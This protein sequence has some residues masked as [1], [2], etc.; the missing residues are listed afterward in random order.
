MLSFNALL[1]HVSSPI[2]EPF[3][4]NCQRHLLASDLEIRARRMM[5]CFANT[6]G[7]LPL[8]ST[9]M[10]SVWNLLPNDT[11]DTMP[12]PLRAD[13]GFLRAPPPTPMNAALAVVNESSS[14]TQ[15]ELPTPDT[16]AFGVASDTCSTDNISSTDDFYESCQHKADKQSSL[17][18]NDS[19]EHA[20]PP[21]D[22][23]NSCPS[24]AEGS[25]FTRPGGS[26]MFAG[27]FEEIVDIKIEELRVHGSGFVVDSLL[28]AGV[29]S[30]QSAPLISMVVRTM[31]HR[32]TKQSSTQ[33]K[34]FERAL[35]AGALE[36]F[37]QHW[38]PDGDWRH[39]SSTS[40]RHSALTLIGVNKAGLMGSLFTAKVITA[41]DIAICL[42]ILLEEIHFDRLCAM[43]A[44]LLYA[45]DRLCK[46]QNLPALI[47][48]KARLF[49]VDPITELY[50]WAPVPHARTLLQ[51]ILDIIEGWMA[52]QVHKRKKYDASY[53]SRKPHLKAVGPRMREGRIRNKA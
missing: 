8:P 28:A 46:T 23:D 10:H 7:T 27:G 42:S 24:D 47:Q 19:E 1:D 38:K 22:Q 30:V 51:D 16:A 25:L 32:M 37:G 21:S 4:K 18:T 20:L 17:E 44:L 34:S 49:L 45:D 15:S 48:L 29:E 13:V 40:G 3:E 12:M 5:E 43:H 2:L 39:I 33:A 52:V 53:A 31:L 36:L 9:T 50:L 26:P 41:E 11:A 14:G 6:T 35:H